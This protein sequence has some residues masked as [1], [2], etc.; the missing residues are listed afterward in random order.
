MSAVCLFYMFSG[1]QLE[2]VTAGGASLSLEVNLVPIAG[3]IALCW[4]YYRFRNSR[5]YGRHRF[6]DRYRKELN[7]SRYLLPWLVRRSLKQGQVL[8]KHPGISAGPGTHTLNCSIADNSGATFKS[9]VEITGVHKRCFVAVVALFCY[10]KHSPEFAEDTIPRLLFWVTCA[11]VVTN[12][13]Y[14]LVNLSLEVLPEALRL[15]ASRS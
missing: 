13:F 9:K 7:N 6:K 12:C 14:P 10:A 8:A 1:A 3:I 11:A 4:F 2:S 5:F 15:K